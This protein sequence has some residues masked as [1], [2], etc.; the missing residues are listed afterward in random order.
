M[1]SLFSRIINL[2]PS[3]EK[4]AQ[5]RKDHH[6]QKLLTS[7]AAAELLGV[8]RATVVRYAIEGT[9]NASHYGRRW[10]FDPEELAQFVRDQRRKGK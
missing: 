2:I 3:F 6:M 8:S 10:R 5:A 1:R 4:R 7:S 9:I